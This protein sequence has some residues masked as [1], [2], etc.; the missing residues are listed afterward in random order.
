MDKLDLILSELET[1]VSIPLMEELTP[2]V[3][4]INMSCML[5]LICM[6]ASGL[7][8]GICLGCFIW[9]CLK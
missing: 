9:R 8:F 6:V 3:D 5:S 7:T 1:M 4:A 2:L